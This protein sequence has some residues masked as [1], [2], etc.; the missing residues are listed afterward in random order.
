VFSVSPEALRRATRL[1]AASFELGSLLDRHNDV[2]TVATE[3]LTVELFDEG[4]EG[5]LSSQSPAKYS[6]IAFS[7]ISTRTAIGRPWVT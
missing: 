4:R 6:W 1:L 3:P 5:K 2:G 7:Q